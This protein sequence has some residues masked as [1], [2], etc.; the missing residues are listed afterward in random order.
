M[1]VDTP[2]GI[3]E[4]I[5]HETQHD[6]WRLDG[7][8]VKGNYISRIQI[9]SGNPSKKIW[10]QQCWCWFT[11]Y[12]TYSQMLVDAFE[13]YFWFPKLFLSLSKNGYKYIY[14][15]I[16]YIYI[17]SFICLY[18]YIMCVWLCQRLFEHQDGILWVEGSY[19][20]RYW[21]VCGKQ[22]SVWQAV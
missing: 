13:I 18:T 15:I 11:T 8:H 1:F 7:K 10:C 14:I 22:F 3:F 4:S 2:A 17:Y 6:F 20:R 21:K 5:P 12:I 16:Y 19:P 9:N